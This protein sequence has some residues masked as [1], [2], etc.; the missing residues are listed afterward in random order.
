M[1]LREKTSTKH[2]KNTVWELCTLGVDP[3]YPSELP[4]GPQRCHEAKLSR[5]S[6]PSA[7]CR[8]KEILSLQFKRSTSKN[9]FGFPA[10][11]PVP[12]GR[13]GGSAA[14]APQ[15]AAPKCPQ[16]HP[17][18]TNP[19]PA[20]TGRSFPHLSSKAPLFPELWQAQEQNFD[21]FPRLFRILSSSQMFGVCCVY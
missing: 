1:G 8:Y 3:F 13:R 5:N 19:P 21:P 14:S 17:Q 7:L 10:A 12:S 11:F 20:G 6:N 4:S 9:Q 15:T 2:Q 16:R 18:G